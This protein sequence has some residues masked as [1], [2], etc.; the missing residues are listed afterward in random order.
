MADPRP[1]VVAHGPWPVSLNAMVR[2]EEL[3]NSVT[4]VGVAAAHDGALLVADDVGGI[5]WR[6]TP[7]LAGAPA[8]K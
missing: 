7:T 5:V 8:K 6:V 4:E 3:K 1:A 2:A